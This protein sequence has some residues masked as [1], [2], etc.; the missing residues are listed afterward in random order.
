VAKCFAAFSQ[1]SKITPKPGKK[2]GEITKIDN[3]E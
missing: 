3:Q 1:L 2:K